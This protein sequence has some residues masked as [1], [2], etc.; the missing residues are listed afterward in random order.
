MIVDTAAMITLVN[1]K[2]IHEDIEC[3]ETVTLRGLGEQL[4][5]GKIIRNTLL[6]IDGDIP[7]CIKRLR[8]TLF[9]AESEMDES[10]DDLD[11]T[12]PYGV[13]FNVQGMFDS[14][15]PTFD[16]VVLPQSLGDPSYT[17]TPLTQELEQGPQCDTVTVLDANS[18]D[19]SPNLDL[20]EILSSDKGYSGDIVNAKLSS[21]DDEPR[22]SAFPSSEHTSRYG[23]PIRCPLRY[24]T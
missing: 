6:N 11:D 16:S 1:E 5:I 24:Q 12:I 17:H 8:H 4:V 14:N 13:D 2:L 21:T 18:I 9:Q 3:P 23:R 22:P 20:G 10:W 7:T 19:E 15:L